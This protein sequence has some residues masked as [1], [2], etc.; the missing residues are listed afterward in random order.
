MAGRTFPASQIPFR[1]RVRPIFFYFIS[2]VTLYQKITKKAP[3][4]A[5]YFITLFLQDFYHL[6]IYSL[7]IH[8]YKP[9]HL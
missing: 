3:Y 5:F 6:S 8:Q 9:Q 4:G 2:S 1:V 7:K